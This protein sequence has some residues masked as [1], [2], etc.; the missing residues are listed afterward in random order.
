MQVDA[1]DEIGQRVV[2]IGGV[3]APPGFVADHDR[4]RLRAM[5]QAQ[6]DRRVGGMEQRSLSLDDVPAIR[7]AVCPVARNVAFAPRRC[8]S[9]VIASAEYFLPTAQSVPT[10]KTRMPVRLRPLPMGRFGGGTRTSTRV[11]PPAAAA[12]ARPGTDPNLW[13]IPA[14]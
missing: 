6:A 3:G 2:G 8:S 12:S 4:I 11:A 10:V 7:R 1:F 14:T 5:E 9:R 13:C